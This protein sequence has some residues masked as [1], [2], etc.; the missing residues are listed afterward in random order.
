[1]VGSKSS[2]ISHVCIT[3]WIRSKAA[4]EEDWG[5]GMEGVWLGGRS[6]RDHGSD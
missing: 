3:F 1:M 5:G 4:C 2:R 6:G